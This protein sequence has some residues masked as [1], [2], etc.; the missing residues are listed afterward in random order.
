MIRLSQLTVIRGT[1]VLLETAD[2]I[3]RIVGTT[4]P[5]LPDA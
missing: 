4:A 3:E 2:L 5:G 1:K